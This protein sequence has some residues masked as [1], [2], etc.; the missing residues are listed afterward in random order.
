MA[1]SIILPL[2]LA[3]IIGFS[4]HASALPAGLFP[5][6]IPEELF[7][8]FKIINIT[9]ETSVH[10]EVVTEVNVMTQSPSTWSTSTQS[11]SLNSAPLY[12]ASHSISHY[13]NSA[14][15]HYTY[16]NYR[17]PNH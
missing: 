7:P 1:K 5:D 9:N 4:Q 2:L 16:S 13:I 11:A 6:V 3:G 14:S 10:E 17:T 8:P 12:A 15:P